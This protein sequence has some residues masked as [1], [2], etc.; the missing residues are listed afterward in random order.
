[1][2]IDPGKRKLLKALGAG[3]ALGVGLKTGV[4]PAAW[5][6]PVVDS[7]IPSAHAQLD[8]TPSPSPAP[9][10]T[11]AP[12]AEPVPAATTAVLAAIAGS[13]SYFGARVLGRTSKAKRRD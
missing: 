2:A 11:P 5:V 6:K 3:S 7:V 4:I 8:P 10:P 12:M 13:L 1:M 9:A